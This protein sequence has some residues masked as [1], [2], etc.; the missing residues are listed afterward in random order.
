M[1][2]TVRCGELPRVAIVSIPRLF[3]R[4][5]R[6]S[7]GIGLRLQVENRIDCRGSRAITNPRHD[8][9]LIGTDNVGDITQHMFSL[10]SKSE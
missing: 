10:L 8:G 2:L 5:E 3:A 7:V 1:V 9:V 6:P 4:I